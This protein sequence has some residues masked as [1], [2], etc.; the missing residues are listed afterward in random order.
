VGCGLVLNPKDELS[1]FFTRNA[2]LIGKF[3]ELGLG[4]GSNAN[5]Q[6]KMGA[7]SIAKSN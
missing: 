7:K 1:I 6:D 5:E 4:S 2:R 3:R